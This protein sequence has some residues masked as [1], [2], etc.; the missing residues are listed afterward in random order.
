[1]SGTVSADTRK[2]SPDEEL[3]YAILSAWSNP[4]QLEETTTDGPP[5]NCYY[6]GALHFNV[7]AYFGGDD[8]ENIPT[9]V[10]PKKYLI[11]PR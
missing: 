6:N 7:A 1:M 5:W 9:N 11:Q 4:S 8:G 3:N 10:D 2:F